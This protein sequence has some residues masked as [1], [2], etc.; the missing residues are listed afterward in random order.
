MIKDA[1]DELTTNASIINAY[2]NYV[3]GEGLV[4][5][6]VLESQI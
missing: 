3:L 6:T 4:D 2:S 1:Y 5:L